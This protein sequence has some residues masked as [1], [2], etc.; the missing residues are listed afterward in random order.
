M[1]YETPDHTHLNPHEAPPQALKDLFKLWKGSSVKSIDQLG[2]VSDDMK[3]LGYV[4]KSRLQTALENL[5]TISLDRVS[6]NA[7]VYGSDDL[8]G[9]EKSCV[10]QS[11][12]KWQ[13]IWTPI[14]IFHYCSDFW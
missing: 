4:P 5:P 6:E 11:D 13:Y 14:D 7:S 10:F 3:L 9:R 2:N 12:A 1:D 8:P